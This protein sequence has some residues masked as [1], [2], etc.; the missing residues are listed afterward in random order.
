VLQESYDP[1]D[2]GALPPRRKPPMAKKKMTK[3]GNPT[4]CSESYPLE[5]GLSLSIKKTLTQGCLIIYR[6]GSGLGNAPAQQFGKTKKRLL[7]GA[8][9]LRSSKFTTL[10]R[11]T[12][13]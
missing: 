3:K 13:K 5:T 10:S 1:E 8:A 9:V 6:G 7:A 4:V 2:I 12:G 11:T